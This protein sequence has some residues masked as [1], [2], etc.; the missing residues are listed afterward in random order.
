MKNDRYCMAAFLFGIQPISRN[1]KSPTDP[2]DPPPPPPP[3]DPTKP[4]FN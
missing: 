3:L 1:E 2:T 4:K